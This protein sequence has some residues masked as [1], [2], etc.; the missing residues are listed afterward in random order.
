MKN[1]LKFSTILKRS[2]CLNN[3]NKSSSINNTNK[4]YNDL[5]KMTEDFNGNIAIIQRTLKSYID[6]MCDKDIAST[7]NWQVFKLISIF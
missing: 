6:S 7:N 4:L 3:I 1:S 2:Q 5:V